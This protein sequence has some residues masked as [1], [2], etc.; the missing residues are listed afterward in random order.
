MPDVVNQLNWEKKAEHY[1]VYNFYRH[2]IALRRISP[3]LRLSSADEVNQKL[4]FEK[5]NDSNLI[6]YRYLGD[7][8]TPEIVVVHANKSF[9]SYTPDKDYI[10]ITDI[11]G[12]LD[13]HGISKVKSGTA[14][15]ILNYN[16]LILVEDN[17]MFNY[18]PGA[19]PYTFYTESSDVNLGVILAIS[20]TIVVI[21][22][23][24]A[25]GYIIYKRQP[26]D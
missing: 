25:I 3:N 9:G 2:L 14:I 17:G 10:S 4:V 8:N 19:K 5:T 21:G 13:A 18:N 20:I 7:E 12:N 16:T 6:A 22:L 15:N 11:E 1:D 26:Q 23:G 24:G